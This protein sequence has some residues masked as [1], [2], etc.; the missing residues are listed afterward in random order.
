[1]L[2]LI[3][4]ATTK[5]VYS[6]QSFSPT[7]DRSPCDSC[8]GRIPFSHRRFFSL[9]GNKG[10]FVEDILEEYEEMREDCWARRSLLLNLRAGQSSEKGHRL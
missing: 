10:S 5:D 9:G 1:V 2:L 6:R 3:G 7:I 4:G 8:S